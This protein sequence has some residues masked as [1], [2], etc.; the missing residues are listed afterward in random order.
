MIVV[1]L[2]VFTCACTKKLIDRTSERTKMHRKRSAP[3]SK[4]CFL[5]AVEPDCVFRWNKGTLVINLHHVNFF[6]QSYSPQHVPSYRIPWNTKL[7]HSFQLTKD[8]CFC[9]CVWPLYYCCSSKS[10]SLKTKQQRLSSFR[11]DRKV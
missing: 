6:R 8:C 1:S 7:N 5:L 9:C 3:R 2:L 11:I 10:P 4:K